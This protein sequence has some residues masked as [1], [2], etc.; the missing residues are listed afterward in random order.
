ML[1]KLLKRTPVYRPL[2]KVYDRL[3][4]EKQF[5]RSFFYFVGK[6]NTFRVI[7]IFPFYHTGGAEQVHLNIV[8]ALNVPSL[9]LFT[10]PSANDHFLEEFKKHTTC[11]DIQ[12]I[13][14]Q[15]WRKTLLQKALTFSINRCSRV[16]VFGCHSL[17][18]YESLPL[19]KSHVRC[20]DLIHAFT[21][22]DEPGY[23]KYSLNYIDRL[24]I[25]VAISK[26]ARQDL[27][28]LY[29]SQAK[30]PSLADRIQVIYNVPGYTCTELPQKSDDTLNVV[31]VGRNS[32]EKRISLI[33]TVATTLKR[34]NPS[35]NFWM[36]GDDLINGVNPEDKASC[37]FCGNITQ[38]KELEQIYRKAH[39]VLILSSREGIP[40]SLMEGMVF[41]AVPCSTDV[42][43][44]RE[45]IFD[46]V[47]GRI[48]NSQKH[49]SKVLNQ[50]FQN[51][52]SLNKMSRNSFN[53][54]K[55]EFNQDTFNSSY[56]KILL[57]KD[58][59]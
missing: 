27:I 24:D 57:E 12:R 4:L 23:E 6:R 11:M 36:V 49:I 29:A 56:M 42:G 45:I 22:S 18:F 51:R 37:E 9:T 16:T 34:H 14:R 33:G 25:R 47:T 52:T 31:Y 28:K 26:H 40:L 46:N 55:E 21:H 44:I 58:D 41:G 53:F 7:F 35:I 20:V 17:F 50:I 48:I 10:L 30:D 5:W 3:T 2:T 15:K 38:K 59:D 43:G 13:I 8:K 32:P 1:K 19:L 54:I 39:V